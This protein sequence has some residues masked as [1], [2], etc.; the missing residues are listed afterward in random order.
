M[1]NNL[2][3]KDFIKILGLGLTSQ[4]L[5]RV[6]HQPLLANL[7]NNLPNILI[8][9]F[10]AWTTENTSLFGYQRKTMPYLEKLAEKAI[11]FHN[12]YA[13]GPFTSPG[14][15]TLI[16]GRYPWSHRA[17]NKAGKMDFRTSHQS[18][19]HELKSDYFQIAYTH[20][21]YADYLLRQQRQEL[22]KYLARPKFYLDKDPI[23]DQLL[24]NDFEAA[25]MVRQ[26]SLYDYNA[27]FQSALFL[28]R[29]YLMLRKDFYELSED[30][31][32]RG[33]PKM[34]ASPERFILEDGIDWLGDNLK[35]WPQP[36]LGYF[37]FLPP[38]SPYNTR[39][40]FVNQFQGDGYTPVDKPIHPLASGADETEMILFRRLYDE[41]LLYVDFEFKR[42]YEKLEQ[43]G[44][45]DNLWIFL[46]SDHG[47]L[48][49][50]GEIEHGT[51]LLF[52]PVV[53]IP[54]LVF[55]PGFSKRFD[56]HTN[57]SAVD[58]LPTI[59]TMAGKE[60][61]EWCEGVPLPIGDNKILRDR[62]VYTIQAWDNPKYEP[63]EEATFMMA[64]E[65]YKIIKAIGYS[66]LDNGPLTEVYNLRND[67]DELENLIDQQPKIAKE[68]EELLDKKI[69]DV[70]RDYKSG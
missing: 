62:S 65:D 23:V 69:E 53:K 27:P 11:V 54:L 20:N 37:H 40:E 4:F 5:P 41:F 70:N 58:I 52:Q 46:T 63:L 38:H 10:D 18:I 59:M 51:R 24:S 67:P 16:S 15:A 26:T 33:I 36:F 7:N 31:Y 22:D 49:E 56:V 39:K 21:S 28:Q 42:L 3:R 60:I 6:I 57:T 19:F 55:P 14:T 43:Q 29:L 30:M 12:H 44:V 66:V 35:T 32:P 68:L 45:L 17:I 9:V 25:N 64:I 47:E 34:G 8:I 61:P 50:R 2:S 13:G 1:R 48:F